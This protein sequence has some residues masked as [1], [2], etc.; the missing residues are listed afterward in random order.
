MAFVA[1]CV[2][3]TGE[4]QSEVIGWSRVLT[5]RQREREKQT[6]RGTVKDTDTEKHGWVRWGSSVYPVSITDY[7]VEPPFLTNIWYLYKED[8]ATYSISVG[9][10]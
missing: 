6:V 8:W 9:H 4:G 3:R 2:V 1:A 7:S 10:S 5:E